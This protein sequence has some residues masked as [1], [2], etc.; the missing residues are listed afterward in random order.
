MIVSEKVKK[1]LAYEIYYET[2]KV[3]KCDPTDWDRETEEMKNKF[4]HLALFALMSL[5]S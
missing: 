4:Y 5:E 1:D 3:Q 2:C